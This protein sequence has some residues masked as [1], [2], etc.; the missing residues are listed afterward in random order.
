MATPD[1]PDRDIPTAALAT[2]GPEAEAVLSAAER[3]HCLSL[4]HR[5]RADFRAG[6]LAAKRAVARRIG[7]GEGRDEPAGM[8]GV[9]IH[10]VPGRP[11]LARLPSST[12]A[13]EPTLLL[14][15]AHRDGRAAATAAAGGSRVGVDLEREGVVERSELRLFLSEEERE[16][17][18]DLD[19]TTLWTLKEAAWKALGVRRTDPFHSLALLFRDGELAEAGHRGRRWPAR[20]RT[21]R[22]W[23]GYL[24]TVVGMGDPS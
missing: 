10:S 24:V 21:T 18:L 1:T 3:R 15:I 8:G 14:S 13:A 20:A 5:R 12:G 17:A 6:R 22:P 19:P 23:P 2:D 4:P 11:P 16:Q 7:I 9:T